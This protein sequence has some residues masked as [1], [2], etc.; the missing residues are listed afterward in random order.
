MP[1]L[2]K[3]L[4]RCAAHVR[5]ALTSLGARMQKN[6]P[7]RRNTSTCPISE[8]FY[9]YLPRFSIPL[10]QTCTGTRTSPDCTETSSLYK[11]VW[12][13]SNA[14]AAV[15]P[16]GAYQPRSARKPAKQPGSPKMDWSQIE[17]CLPLVLCSI[18]ALQAARTKRAGRNAFGTSEL[19]RPKISGR[20][21]PRWTL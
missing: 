13:A 5:A 19:L 15:H 14:P 21:S 17:V 8:P 12:T 20:K 9:M 10:K 1:R 18:E 7:L 4:D 2:V 3:A 11:G 16:F 6:L